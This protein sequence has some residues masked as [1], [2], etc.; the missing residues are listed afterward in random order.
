MAA[1]D[2]ALL[3]FYY[4]SI[5]VNSLKSA[6]VCGIKS[7]RMLGTLSERDAAIEGNLRPE[8]P[9]IL[10]DDPRNGITMMMTHSIFMRVMEI[11]FMRLSHA[12]IVLYQV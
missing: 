8:E 3:S 10:R 1:R 12:I 5:G 4:Q 7:P 2:F 9:N 6:Y 11:S